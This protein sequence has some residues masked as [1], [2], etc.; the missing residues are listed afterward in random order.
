MHGR[1]NN[2]ATKTSPRKTWFKNGRIEE[3]KSE[4]QDLTVFDDLTVIW[5]K[6][7]T[8]SSTYSA[9]CLPN[10]GKIR[11]KSGKNQGKIREIIS[12]DNDK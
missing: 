4:N 12:C 3:H 1:Q 8:Q 7:G 6:I 10:H 11:G 5:H 9:V 2:L